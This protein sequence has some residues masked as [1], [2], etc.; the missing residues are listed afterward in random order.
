MYSIFSPRREH[1]IDFNVDNP[2][3]LQD[4]LQLMA[5][6][7]YSQSS[8]MP[9]LPV[10]DGLEGTNDSL[11]SYEASLEA[12]V[13][14]FIVNGPTFFAPENQEDISLAPPSYEDSLQAPISIIEAYNADP[15][16]DYEEPQQ[17]L[18]G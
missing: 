8:V 1:D 4:C 17:M 12:L 5:R 9:F 18:A 3:S 15:L 11:P 7:L 13:P 2:L 14:S 16:P 6:R 10:E